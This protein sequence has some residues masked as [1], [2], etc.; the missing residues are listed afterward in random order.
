MESALTIDPEQII[1]IAV[2]NNGVWH[3]L[4]IYTFQG[5]YIPIRTILPSYYY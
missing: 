5:T 4:P 3:W 1:N 2:K